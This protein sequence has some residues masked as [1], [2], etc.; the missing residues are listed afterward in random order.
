MTA[1]IRVVGL[2][3]TAATMYREIAIEQCHPHYYDAIQTSSV[4]VL[5][6]RGLLPPGCSSPEI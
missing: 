6:L 2:D 5:L 1:D 3:Q 4:R